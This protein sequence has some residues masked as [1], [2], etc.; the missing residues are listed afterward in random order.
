MALWDFIEAA[1]L[2]GHRFVGDATGEIHLASL[3]GGTSLADDIALFRGKSVLIRSAGQR[4]AV[5]ALAELDGV[6]RRLVL[7]PADLPPE[8]LPGVIAEAD[9]DVLL[10]DDLDAVAG[11]AGSAK[12]APCGMAVRHTGV[13]PVRDTESEWLLFTSGTTGRPKMVVHSLA[14]LTGP[15][16]DGLKVS[17]D[18][19]W[20]TFYD[21][22]R[23]GGLQILMRA[24]LGGGSMVLSDT[25]ETLAAFLARAGALGVTHISG[26]PSHWR[27]ALMSGAANAMHPD[28][29]R[30]SGE[31]ADQGILNALRQCYPAA[32]IAHAFASTEAGVAFDVRDGLAGFPAVLVGAQGGAAEIRVVDG[33]LQIRSN[34]LA[35]GYLNPA[36]AALRDADGFVDTGDIVALRDG[37]YYFIGRREGQ[38]NVGGQKVHPEEV[39]AVLNRHPMVQMSRVL[40]RP[41]P[42][43][44][45]I[46][47]AD[48][49]VQTL[50]EAMPDFQTISAQ[51]MADC[52]AMLP[53]HKVPAMLRQVE[54]LEVAASGKLVRPRA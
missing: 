41:S 31:V 1:G 53:P 52:R 33:C 17:P 38:I 32:Q 20:S 46:V 2:P 4:P 19:V 3:K 47:V 21:V 14:S 24:L 40:A 6:A 22:R 37:R 23:Y 44:G 5:L 35:Q 8:S 25:R 13:R 28:Y 49:V 54:A 16:Q 51:I 43:T 15:L 26:T 18:A 7:C 36:H 34:R 29:V 12:V 9:V 11:L 27:R 30:L 45:A 39:E 10:T 50:S 48:I 42:I